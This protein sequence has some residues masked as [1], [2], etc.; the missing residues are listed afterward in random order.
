MSRR[1]DYVVAWLEVRG[2]R[3]EILVRPEHA[4]KFK[5][6]E[7]VDLDDVLWTDTIY[8]DVRK[9]LKASPEAVRRAFGTDDPR[10]VAERILREGEIQLTEEQRRKMLE[11]KKRKIIAYIARNAVDPKTGKPIP[12][13]RIE[14]AMEELRIGVDLYKPAE[15][16]AVEI[17]RRLARVMP[18][19]LARAVVHARIPPQFSGRIYR[20]LARLGEVKKADW[21]HDGSLIVELEIPAGAQVDV[22]NTIQKLTRGQAQVSV[23]VV[24]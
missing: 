12:E 24:K 16:Q 10:R 4:F 15:A 2:Q 5:E 20:E 14:A 17:V 1:H 9:G 6:G 7:K 19:K 18:I 11:A 22:V 8:R 3:F 23:R 13:S 21:G